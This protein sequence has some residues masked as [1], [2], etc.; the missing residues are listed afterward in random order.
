MGQERRL[1]DG[2]D[3]GRGRLERG[4]GV[5]HA[6]RDRSFLLG[7]LRHGGHDVGRADRSIGPVV[8]LDG[9]GLEALLGGPIVIGDHGHGVVEGD[10]AVHAGHRERGRLVEGA[11]RA[12]EHGRRRNGGDLHARH[13]HVDAEHRGAVHLPGHVQP[14][15]W[16]A[17][18]AEGARILQ[19]YLGRDGQLRRRIHQVAIADPPAARGVQ[20]HAGLGRERARVDLPGCSGSGDDHLARGGA[21]LTQ[22]QVE[23]A[24]RRRVARDLQ[25]ADIRI[26]IERVI[27]RGMVDQH[28][29][30]VDVQLLR[31][32][33]RQGRVGPL[34]HLDLGRDDRDLALPVDADEGVR[35]EDGG[36]GRGR[37]GQPP[38]D[39]QAAAERGRGLQE[40][41]PRRAWIGPRHDLGHGRSPCALSDSAACLIA[42]RMRT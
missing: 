1:V 15:G 38:A 31:D 37:G 35:R 21:G 39:D 34:A 7:C 23:G 13:L 18:D 10:D 42:S 22:R 16:R 28:V 4:G 27:R 8:E 41:A 30:H 20:H 11:D 33:H 12:A 2:F 36:A 25:A 14:L 6:L 40:R 24:N 19:L 17:D 26:A 3:P 29:G 5:T 32:Q 9:G